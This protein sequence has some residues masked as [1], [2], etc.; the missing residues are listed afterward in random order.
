MVRTHINNHY[1]KLF[2]MSK[3]FAPGQAPDESNYDDAYYDT[4]I[5]PLIICNGG[6]MDN[7][8]VYV[9]GAISAGAS[10]TITTYGYSAIEYFSIGDNVYQYKIADNN[11]D[12]LG[13]VS[14]VTDTSITFTT[15]V[16][17]N[18]L[19]ATTLRTDRNWVACYE[20]R[21][22]KEGPAN[23][24]KHS[25]R[26]VTAINS[27]DTTLNISN[28]SSFTGTGFIKINN[29]VIRYTGQ[30]TTNLTTIV[31]YRGFGTTTAAS[32]I[33]GDIVYEIANPWNSDFKNMH[34]V[35]NSDDYSVLNR[36]YPNDN[37]PNSFLSNIGNTIGFKIKTY[38]GITP[39]DSTV[40]ANATYSLSSSFNI[41]V[42]SDPTNI[43]NT[44]DT[45]FDSSSNKIGEIKS[46]SSTSIYLTTLNQIAI[47][48]GNDIYM[49]GKG[50]IL[51]SN[52]IDDNDHFIILFADDTTKHHIAKITSISTADIAGDSLEFS[53]AFGSE[54]PKDTKYAIYKGP[55][56]EKELIITSVT[57]AN[58]AVFTTST[59]HNY[60]IGDEVTITNCNATI[61]NNQ[62]LIN[63]KHIIKTVP[64]TTTFE[65]DNSLGGIL[66]TSGTGDKG[67]IKLIS[68]VVAIGYGLY[69]K[70]SKVS[71]LTGGTHSYPVWFQK[72]ESDTDATDGTGFSKD[73]RHIGMTYLNS[74]NFYFYNDRLD[75]KNSLDFNTKYKI[76]YSR[77]SGLQETHYQRCFLTQR[78]YGNSVIDYSRYGMNAILTDKL[79]IKD[80]IN[81]SGQSIEHYNESTN[82]SYAI[83]MADWQECFINANRSNKDLRRN[84][85]PLLHS[86]DGP[87]RYLHYDT[88]PSSTNIV[89]EVQNVEI[90]ESSDGLSSYSEINILDIKKIY[91]SKIKRFDPFQVRKIVN[92]GILKKEFKGILPGIATATI[93]TSI[94]TVE[95]LIVNQDLKPLLKYGDE[96][97]TI[98]IGD[99][100]Y[101]PS[102]IAAPVIYSGQL[103]KQD[104]T[105]AAYRKYDS[106]TWYYVSS[107]SI[108]IT[109]TG[110][111]IYRKM[112][113]PITKTLITEELEIDTDITYTNIGEVNQTVS[114]KFGKTVLV[115]TAQS[116]LNKLKLVLIDGD[117]NGYEFD[118]EYGDK[119]LNYIKLKM[120][121]NIYLSDANILDFY[122]GHYVIEKIPIKGTVEDIEDYIE[123]G[124]LKYKISGRNKSSKLIGPIINKD[125]KFSDDIVYSTIGP[126]ID[127][128]DS[129]ALINS[130]STIY[131]V[132]TT[133]LTI[134]GTHTLIAGDNIFTDNGTLIGQVT[135]TS[136]PTTSLTIG[137]GILIRL[138]DNSKLYRAKTDRN[139]LSFAKA[140]SSNP[141]NATTTSLSGASDKGLVFTSGNSIT[142]VLGIPETE[143]TTLTGTSSSSNK[144][145]LGYALNLPDAIDLD[146]PFY[147]KLADETSTATYN[148]IHTPSSISEYNIVSI[149]KNAG[150]T[151]IELAP[152]C[153][154]VLGRIDENPEDIRLLANNLIST[155]IQVY[156]DASIST[157]YTLRTTSN[158]YTI[159]GEDGQTTEIGDHLYTENGSY[160]GKLIFKYKFID[161]ISIDA[162][163]ADV[164]YLCFDKQRI[165]N[166]SSAVEQ[167][168]LY[169]V[170]K[171]YQHLYLA[172]TQGLSNGGNL[173]L[174]N[175]LLS[176]NGMTMQYSAGLL[177]NNS[178]TTI[179]SDIITRYGE[180]NYRFFNLQR[181]KKGSLGYRKLD[182]TNSLS[183][184]IT[185]L[186]FKDFYTE[187]LGKINNYALVYQFKPGIISNKINITKFTST[188]INSFT[189]LPIPNRGLVPASNSAFHDSTNSDTTLW[190]SLG[191]SRVDGDC[192]EFRV[193]NDNPVQ[194]VKDTWDHV[195]PKTTTLFMFGASDLYPESK[196]RGNHLFNQTRNLTDY[197]LFIKNSTTKKPSGVIHTNYAGSLPEDAS[198][199]DTFETINIDSS[200]VTSDQIKRFGLLRLVEM[201]Y[202]WR[203]NSYDFENPPSNKRSII[204][205]EF[206]TRWYPTTNSGDTVSSTLNDVITCSASA[207]GC[208]INDRVYTDKGHYLGLI[209]SVSGNDYTL[210]N[211]VNYDPETIIQ[212]HYTVQYLLKL[213]V[214]FL[215]ILINLLV[216][217]L[218][219][220]DLVLVIQCTNLKPK[221]MVMLVLLV[222]YRGQKKVLVQ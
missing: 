119:Q 107:S 51:P 219:T 180:G 96:Y 151:V 178:N 17:S 70:R 199:D 60:S 126:V 30:S 214:M 27:T 204:Q 167:I 16:L 202:D 99:Y 87:S 72:Y 62:H 193:E 166:P 44:G 145:A 65:I 122:D 128:E 91:G 170:N 136:T 162:S 67:S 175:S 58:P 18:V 206:Y 176:V 63:G 157:G 192:Y 49:G 83:D 85:E 8:L 196:K 132:G 79:K 7:T 59:A 173:Q 75:K 161:G 168:V 31:S 29:E 73:S 198:T 42:S 163:L 118:I 187:N 203:F 121:R 130:P 47:T 218:L 39:I 160:V 86:F 222:L 34:G 1:N 95:Q 185:D 129:S 217:M 108:P 140:M 133:T 116:R 155:N 5:N 215:L 98:R 78:N 110:N 181:G 209:E 125:F 188:S 4:P 207:T 94:I 183:S 111:A 138:T 189:Q 68:P 10:N 40:N 53:P 25:S 43:F 177:D 77:S 54:I 93:G 142:K 55:K 152:N 191:K 105:I 88:S 23:S 134:D 216:M 148:E 135:N 45:I 69:G 12:L 221:F 61:Y 37:R 81:Q 33:V 127:I 117:L 210:Y 19:T 153:P 120:Y 66:R 174:M 35:S 100:Y 158:I 144:D 26:L 21:K 197:N 172:N 124:F 2:V 52:L 141:V 156:P 112:W 15:N 208:V 146:L 74:P 89:P 36:I 11:T 38:S 90:K 14:A 212:E 56:V 186:K 3:G 64:S 123:E 150:Q 169:R 149:D 205:T 184:N 46:L 92:K 6:E 115:S 101:K 106:P 82:V 24:A 165:Y 71:T 143:G 9:N 20:I 220:V 194:K 179:D 164:Y 182:I 32:H 109:I 114:L 159:T 102:A 13:E 48:S 28:T 213:M 171:Q 154:I 104:I 195:D 103:Y 80:T 84:V 76:H 97:E 139:N 147:S 41:S 201:T 50:I 22:N 211:K 190:D 131:E 200:N 137:S 57:S 113:S